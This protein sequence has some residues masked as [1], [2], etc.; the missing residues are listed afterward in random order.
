MEETRAE[1][2]DDEWQIREHAVVWLR[3]N[4]GVPP[5]ERESRPGDGIAVR[6]GLMLH[7]AETAT[8][9]RLQRRNLLKRMARLQQTRFSFPASL[10]LKLSRCFLVNAAE[11]RV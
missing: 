10:T 8:L 5:D 4:C 2:C 3:D 7:T 1:V 6:N 11:L 9:E